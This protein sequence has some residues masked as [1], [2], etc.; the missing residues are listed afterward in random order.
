MSGEASKQMLKQFVTSAIHLTLLIT[1]IDFASKY[2]NNMPCP[3]ERP[4]QTE[5]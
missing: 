5:Y 2:N 1:H 3:H 4:G